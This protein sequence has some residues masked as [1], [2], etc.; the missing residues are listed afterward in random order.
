VPN[1]LVSIIIPCYNQ[2]HFLVEAIESVLA[3]TY[4]NFE[5]I[6]VDDGSSDNT[7]EVA[8]R[9]PEARLIRQGNQGLAGARNTGIRE[10]KGNYLIFLDADD[11]LVHNA[12]EIGLDYLNTYPE[13]AF[14]YGH[15]R[16]I[17]PDGYPLN[18]QKPRC[19][20]EEQYREMLCSDYIGFPATVMYR[21]AI[22]NSLG[23]FKTSLKAREDYELYLRITKEFKICCHDKVVAE[24]RMHDASMSRNYALMIKSGFAVLRMQRKYIKGNS[25]YKE[26]YKTGIR[27]QRVVYGEQLLNEVRIHMHAHRWKQVIKAVLVLLRYYPRGLIRHISPRFLFHLY[28]ILFRLLICT[29]F[30]IKLKPDYGITTVY[31]GYHDGADCNLINGWVRDMNNPDSTVYVDIFDNRTLLA[32]VKAG[33]FRK[34]LVDAGKGNGKHAFHYPVPCCLK[35]GK[36]HLIQVKVTG[37]DFNLGDTPKKINCTLK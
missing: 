37:T 14:V 17:S 30:F 7:S 9:C 6:V 19:V 16:T 1:N 22:F 28:A 15:Y 34:D 10:S 25:R 24:Y 13:C 5:I 27:N 3:Q 18:E 11:R 12:I 33:E 8:G 23:G 20:T 36:S 29:R 26:A 21:R 32:T 2:A 31:E 4:R 35:D